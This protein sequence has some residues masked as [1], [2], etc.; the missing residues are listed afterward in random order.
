MTSINAPQDVKEV[1]LFTGEE[2]NDSEN[3]N[4]FLSYLGS[5][6]KTLD[7]CVYTISDDEISRIIIALH[8]RYP[9]H[10]LY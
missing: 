6:V 2:E 9:T 10:C 4:T 7:I 8:K 3:F 5:A 1:L